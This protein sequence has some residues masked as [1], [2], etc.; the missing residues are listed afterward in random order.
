MPN[1]DTMRLDGRAVLERLAELP[2]GGQLLALAGE[3]ADVELIGGAT[4]DLLLGDVPRELDVV[5][6]GSAEAFAARI[7]TMIDDGRFAAD[8]PGRCRLETHERFG[9]ASISWQG[10][11]VDVA[12]RRAESYAAPGS[13]P[14]VRPG[15]A[16]QDLGRRDFTVNA[17]AVALGGERRGELRAAPDALDDL[18]AGRLR[19]LHDQSFSDD[20]T[21]LLRLGRYAARLGFAVEEHT[22]AL[23]AAAI[24]AGAL[25]TISGA[26]FGAE[27]R[28]ALGEADA[29]AALAALARLGALAALDP[30][31]GVDA[32][33]ARAA[34]TELPADGRPEVLLL[35]ILLCSRAGDPDAA[36]DA[37]EPALRRLLDR[38]EF[39]AAER[40][41]ALSAALA[42]PA[43]AACLAHDPSPSRLHE[44]AHAQT[45][46]TVALAA[47]LAA[48]RSD[49]RA[50]QLARRWLGELR[51]V[52]LQIGGEDL[53]AAGVSPGPEIGSRLERALRLRLDG[54]L[55]PGREAELAAALEDA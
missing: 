23:A 1:V 41:A 52:R 3:R 10:G 37:V 26:R 17:I 9:T 36:D 45:V 47:A 54:R 11:R 21:R 20:P 25:A 2:G 13:L 53:I 6:D 34:L 22:A 31:L 18:A 7:A 27:L 55:A 29:A 8:V 43:L 32:E 24:S 30:A 5:V 48:R 12:G 19:V 35:A 50:A 4:R 44:L 16:E 49:P 28:L 15:T 51:A 38:L 14:D 33:L 42:A 39:G 46:E 40:D